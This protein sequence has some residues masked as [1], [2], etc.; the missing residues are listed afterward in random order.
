MAKERVVVLGAGF[1]GVCVALGLARRGHAVTLIDKSPDCM[2]RASLRNEGKIHLGFVYANDPSF[3][4]ASLLLRSALSFAGLVE[5]WVGAEVTWDALKSHPF[6]YAIARDSLLP[7]EKI[8][9]HYERL[10]EEYRGMAGARGAS[11][12][13][14]QAKELWR[15]LPTGALNDVVSADFAEQF[16]ST[17]EVA[18]DRAEFRL[19]LRG[20]LNA[21]RGVKQLY[22]HRVE[23]VARTAAGFRVG[24]V[25]CGGEA[26]GCEAGIVVNCLWEGRL[27]LDEKMGL[28]PD[29]KWVY[30]L[31]YRLLGDLP[32]RLASAPSLTCVLGSYG[33]FVVYPTGRIYISWYPACMKGWCGEIATPP[34][35]EGPANGQVDSRFAANLA[36]ETLAEFGRVV[37]GLQNA[38]IDTVDAGVIFSWGESDISDPASRLHERF[39]IGVQAHD[40]YYSIDTGKFTCAPFFAQ[41]FLG[42]I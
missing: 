4:T 6:T 26:W 22:G 15:P 39:D 13:G 12:L 30:R 37:P 11:Y 7:P 20:A 1:L 34:A 23:S 2:L 31:K 8:L 25:N 36:R 41:Q 35:W 5:E 40:G 32:K 42:Q 27:A 29:R 33:D 28:V 14:T 21:S 10:Q 16:A 17:V 3:R 19:L 38:E 18:I 24:G 9:A